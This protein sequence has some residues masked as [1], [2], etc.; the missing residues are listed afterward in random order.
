MFRVLLIGLIV[1]LV[2]GGL[3]L[4][5]VRRWL[6]SWWDNARLRRALVL[7]PVMGLLGVASWTLGLWMDWGAVAYW[8]ANV[9]GLMGVVML[10]L[11]LTVPLSNLLLKASGQKGAS[12]PPEPA[13][14]VGRVEVVDAPRAGITRRQVLGAAAHGAP[15]LMTGALTGGMAMG[16]QLA[17][18][19]PMTF[20]WA[21]LAPQLEGFRILHL[22]DIHIGFYVGLHQLEG[23][24]REA[25]AHKPD[26]ILVTGDLSDDLSRLP[27][28]LALIEGVGAPY[29]A[30]ASIGNHEYFRGLRQ[31]KAAHARSGV[32]LL[33]E[34][35]TTLDVDGATLCLAGADD[36]VR[37]RGDISA[38]LRK[39]VSAALK[40]RPDERA[41]F[42]VMMSHRPR[43]FEAASDMGVELTLSGHTHGGQV[44]WGGRSVFDVQARYLWGHY[45]KREGSQLYTSS[46][47]GHWLPLR[48]GCPTEAPLITL[49]SPP[50]R[51]HGPGEGRGS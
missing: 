19:K 11:T 49:R 40:G 44:G 2:L 23:L 37:L 21:G 18:I 6:P 3:A 16:S 46:G 22:S 48:I 15:A 35:A 13:R 32:P 33:L 9:S 47:V 42:T 29:G 17:A 14:E 30:W 1:H 28:A 34:S 24:L 25:A 38:F 20:E 10:G 31:V 8:S 51:S 4:S 50:L 41:D 43:G 36:P 12:A 7:V 39:T 5:M 45:K 26:L 27:Q